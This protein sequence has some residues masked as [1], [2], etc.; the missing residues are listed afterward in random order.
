MQ[1]YFS[2][3]HIFSPLGITSASFYFTPDFKARNL[4]LAVRDSENK[5]VPF[6]NQIEIIDRDPE[7]SNAPSGYPGIR[8][9]FSPSQCPFRRSGA[10]LGEIFL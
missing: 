6:N 8:L 1:S 4:P 2:K 9:L 3:D 5:L 7:K 10:L